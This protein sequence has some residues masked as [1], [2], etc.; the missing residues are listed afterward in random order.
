M[1]IASETGKIEGS[2]VQV[3]LDWPPTVNHY[4]TVARGRKILSKAG[5]SYKET[6]RW[7]MKAQRIPVKSSGRFAVHIHCFPPDRRRRDLDNL[8]KPILDV[9]VEYGA[10]TDDADI[11]DLS[12]CRQ[13][14][15]KPGLVQVFIREA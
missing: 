10:I 3:M 5:R 15:N 1:T 12:I 9:L 4:Y 11:D 14:V 6:Q 7:Q 2:L 13:A 8:L